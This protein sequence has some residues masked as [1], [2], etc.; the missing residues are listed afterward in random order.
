MDEFDAKTILHDCLF[1]TLIHFLAS[2]GVFDMQD[3]LKVFDGVVVGA[4]SMHPNMDM[5]QAVAEFRESLTI[6]PQELQS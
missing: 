4:C 2:R 6:W 3:F 1:I 5:D